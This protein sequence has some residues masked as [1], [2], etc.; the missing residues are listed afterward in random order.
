[1]ERSQNALRGPVAAFLAL[2]SDFPI[3][4]VRRAPYTPFHR[5]GAA[6][7]RLVGEGFDGLRDCRWSGADPGNWIG[8]SLSFSSRG[9]D[10]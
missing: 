5:R 10:R 2:I 4:A 8:R 3:D 7:H 9:V 1:M 6:V